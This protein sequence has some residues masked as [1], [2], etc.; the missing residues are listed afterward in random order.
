MEE[1][2]KFK[3]SIN[4][5]I[6][7]NILD[8]TNSRLWLY[9]I[10]TL[11]ISYAYHNSIFLKQTYH[12][13]YITIFLLVLNIIFQ[14]IKYKIIRNSTKNKIIIIE[15]ISDALI[16]TSLIIIVF[17][18][19]FFRMYLRKYLN[20]TQ[21]IDKLTD[22]IV[23]SGTIDNLEFFSNKYR[24][25]VKDI[26]SKNISTQVNKFL[27]NININEYEQHNLKIGDHIK[28]NAFIKPISQPI[29]IGD[30]NYQRYLFYQNIS[31]LGK[32]TKIIDKEQINYKHNPIDYIFYSIKNIRY[33]IS[34]YIKNNSKFNTKGVLLSIITG[35]QHLINKK[36]QNNYRKSGISHL[37]A[38]SGFHMG[39]IASFTFMIIR[40][41]L[42]LIYPLSSKYDSKNVA[43]PITITILTLYL[44]LSGSKISTQRA[45]IM[46]VLY[47]VTLMLGKPITSVSLLLKAG[48][49]ILLI[50]PETIVEPGFMLSFTAVL[51]LISV[52]SIPEIKNHIKNIKEKSY[53]C[54][55]IYVSFITS[56]TASIATGILTI[57]YFKEYSIISALSNI[58]AAP[59]FIF[60]VM[61][62]SFLF[63]IFGN[64]SINPLKDMFINFL[65]FS[66]N[67]LNSVANFMGNISN[68]IHVSNIPDWILI[69]FLF[70][71]LIFSIF[72]HKYKFIGL[73]AIIISII[74]TTTLNNHDIVIINK[75]GDIFIKQKSA[76]NI[77]IFNVLI[78]S[79]NTV[80]AQHLKNNKLS[81]RF[82]INVSQIYKIQYDTN[83]KY[84][85]GNSSIVFYTKQF[86]QINIPCF[87]ILQ[88]NTTKEHCMNK[89]NISEIHFKSKN[90]RIYNE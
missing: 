89:N 80:S 21:Q 74:L 5:F 41:L 90:Y 8:F 26:S 13:I 60:M 75:N 77:L 87:K 65:N 84:Y 25:T 57:Y 23:I 22:N 62:A 27:F 35:E 46:T 82:G 6:T 24:L 45:Y 33:K 67:T 42:V 48:L 18:A 52:F 14:L 36:I 66:I 79:T 34:K 1:T 10:F 54:Y 12:F 69:I 56:L 37:L 47:I 11:G 40:F 16:I 72:R 31:G 50:K 61:P 58:V 20:E 17:T 76:Q 43:Y 15:N 53:I 51:S 88:K 38:I 71:I 73:I 55:V 3:K 28:F 9:I 59:I 83:D 68:T 39:I 49:I 32:I 7:E 29:F 4:N 86:N 64:L 81:K 2:I 30:F 78:N 70:G 85:F 63:L 44:F 19:G